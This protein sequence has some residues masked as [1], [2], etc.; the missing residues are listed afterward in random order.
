MAAAF[1]WV[2]DLTSGGPLLPLPESPRYDSVRDICPVPTC[3]RTDSTGLEHPCRGWLGMPGLSLNSPPG[4]RM[5]VSGPRHTE[6]RSQV[7]YP[8]WLCDRPHPTSLGYLVSLSP[9]TTSVFGIC[10]LLKYQETQCPP[11]PASWMQRVLATRHGM[12]RKPQV[13]QD[14]TGTVPHT[15]GVFQHRAPRKRSSGLLPHS[16]HGQGSCTQRSGVE[17]AQRNPHPAALSP[18]L[19]EWPPVSTA[20]PKSSTYSVSDAC[21]RH[22]EP[23]H[24]PAF[25][26]THCR[27]SS[28][29][30]WPGCF[31]RSSTMILEKASSWSS[32]AAPRVAVSPWHG[33]KHTRPLPNP[34][35]QPQGPRTSLERSAYGRCLLFSGFS[36][37]GCRLAPLS[38]WLVMEDLQH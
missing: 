21:R 35:P 37:H 28:G 5:P 27:S 30:M 19:P 18:C 32:P 33:A 3:G 17:R 15:E 24:P 23:I 20:V 10:S 1:T 11:L 8:G 34:F 14:S 38:P 16:H 7:W 26:N 36:P 22:M 9:I 29:R 25:T 4:R 6:E 12:H 2:V 13:L 31:F